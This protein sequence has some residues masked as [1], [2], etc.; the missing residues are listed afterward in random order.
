M[1]KRQ[2]SKHVHLYEKVKWGKEG[3][4][5]WKCQVLNCTHYLHVEFILGRTSICYKCGLP[6]TMTPPKLLR[7]KPK[8]DK[9]QQLSGQGPKRID[10][11]VAKKDE[12]SPSIPDLKNIN[13]DDLL[14]NL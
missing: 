8:C 10:K 13:I 6:F 14:E 9:C 2:L 1:T 11:V 12:G 7:K 4:V 5:I 3:T